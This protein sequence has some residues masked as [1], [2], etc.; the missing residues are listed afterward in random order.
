MK[1]VDLNADLGERSADQ[2]I[3]NDRELMR[4]VT[5]ASIACGGHA[6]DSS[7]MRQTVDLAFAT[8]VVIGAHPSYPDRKNFGRLE[9]PASD[10]E[11]FDFVSVQISALS[12]ICA[13]AGARMRYVKPHGALYHRAA[14]DP[15][16]AHAVAAA[17]VGISQSLWVLT[18]SG[19]E[20]QRAAGNAGLAVASEA[21]PDRG[22][23]AHGALVPRN[24]AGANVD[25]PE[26]VANRAVTMVQ[27]SVIDS[28]DGTRIP[29]RADSLCIHGDG[30]RSAS[31]AFAVRSAL[32]ARGIQLRPFAP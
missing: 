4:F 11:I 7:V 12:D 9:M 21:F 15:S 10:S 8:S 18:T 27:S 23:V 22:Y 32:E 29:I 14:T 28:V 13:T 25:D 31:A 26:T 2:P 6:G 1:W 24:Q 30:P 17:I 5:S 3:D 16:A 19:S 20:L